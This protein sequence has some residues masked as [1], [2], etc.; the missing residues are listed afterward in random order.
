MDYTHMRKISHTFSYFHTSWCQAVHICAMCEKA[1]HDLMLLADHCSV[2]RI[3][4]GVV[5][6]SSVNP[7][8]LIQE[9]THCVQVTCLCRHYELAS[10]LI[11]TGST[12][13]STASH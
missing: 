12:E 7:L 5:G 11:G 8:V 13:E 2:K 10:F 6:V 4:S 1:C 9:R 3:Q